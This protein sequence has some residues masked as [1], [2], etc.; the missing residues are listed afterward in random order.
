[1][2]AQSRQMCHAKRRN[3]GHRKAV[4]RQALLVLGM[5]RSGTSALT[6]VLQRL[7]V[8]VPKTLIPANEHNPAGFGESLALADFHDRLLDCA[9]SRWD[10]W[11]GLGPDWFD[12]PNASQ[13]VDECRSLLTQEFG[14]APLFVVKDP[15]LCRLVPFWVRVLQEEN[16]AAAAIVPVRS[17]FEVAR[18]LEARDRLPREQSL[19]MW[20][21]HVLDAEFATRHITRSFVGYRDLLN[22]W[23]AVANRMSA[24][25]QVTWPSQSAA[26]ETA[27][28][29][30]LRHDLCHHFAEIDSE[31]AA[32]PLSEWLIRTYE[33][34]GV[35]LRS[36]NGTSRAYE[37]LD[38]VTHEFDRAASLFGPIVET[39]RSR[40]ADLE[41]QR[42]ALRQEIST[43]ETERENLSQRV[44]HLQSERDALKQHSSNLETRGS[45]LEQQVSN[46]TQHASNLEQQVSNLEQ[47]NALVTRE[48]A[49]ALHHVEALLHSASWRITGPLRAF[50]RILLSHPKARPSR[51]RPE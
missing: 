34:L 25:L 3:E 20:L 48:L 5:H 6:G 23:K 10:T 11:V 9:G 36:G 32:F 45:L 39:A 43:F 51:E 41:G 27:V 24:E 40:V 50:A 7:G 13:L 31:D 26:T 19:L 37:T 42:N 18:S 47:R 35:L 33:A 14:D 28:S 38:E 12:S 29:D 2:P 15:R 1:V 17:P 21:R 44:S 8:R 16:I 46:L 22:D 4:I 30:F 49:G